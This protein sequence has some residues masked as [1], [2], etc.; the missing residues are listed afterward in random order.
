MKKSFLLIGIIVISVFV[1]L[2]TACPPGGDEMLNYT[3]LDTTISAATTAMVGVSRSEHSGSDV[4]PSSKWV[5][6]EVWDSFYEAITH[7]QTVRHSAVTQAQLDNAVVALNNAISE[8]NHAKQDGT[9]STDTTDL[10]ALITQADII[11]DTAIV[12]TDGSEISPSDYWVTQEEMDALIDKITEAENAIDSEQNIDTAYTELNY[13][14]GIFTTA[15]KPGTQDGSD[16]DGAIELNENTW[17]NNTITATDDEQWYKFTATAEEQFIHFSSTSSWLYL[18]MYDSTGNTVGISVNCHDDKVISRTV[19]NGEIYYIKVWKT[20]N[21][22][23]ET[24]RIAFNRSFIEPETIVTALTEDIWTNGILTETNNEQWFKF[25]ATTN[26]QYIHFEPGSLNVVYVQVYDLNGNT[27]ENTEELHSSNPRIPILVTIGQH[28]VVKVWSYTSY[29]GTFKMAFNSLSIPPATVLAENTWMDS[30]I[31]TTNLEQWFK[32][33]A[34]SNTQ[35]IHFSPGTL[36]DIYVEIFNSSGISIR[37][38]YLNS[39]TASISQTLT[40]GEE[41]FV[42]ITPSISG[43]TGTYRIAFN[44]S[45]TVTPVAS[46]TELVEK[47]WTDGN[48]IV[49]SAGQMFKFIATASEQFIHFSPGTLA[50]V[51]VQLYDSNGSGVGYQT[52]LYGSGSNLRTSRDL[53]IGQEYYVRILPYTSNSTGTYQIA[54]GSII[55]ISDFIVTSG[56]SWADGNI[57][58]NSREQWFM[59]TATADTHFIHFSDGTLNNIYV[60]VY[61]SN[62]NTEGHWTHFNHENMVSQTVTSGQEYYVWVQPYYSNG[63]GTYRIAFNTSIV[64]P[65]SICTQLTENTWTLGTIAKAGGVQLHRFIATSDTQF[66]HYSP[67]TLSTTQMHVQVFDSNGITHGESITLVNNLGVSLAVTNGQEYYFRV[68]PSSTSSTG[69]Y[70]IMFS[71]SIVA[72]GNSVIELTANTWSSNSITTANREHWYKFTAIADTQYI[73]FNALNWETSTSVYIQVYNSSGSAVEDQTNLYLYYS[74]NSIDLNLSTSRT[75]NS[76]EEYYVRVL[77][78]DTNNIGK[79][80]H[81]GFGSIVPPSGFTI[82]TADTWANGIVSVSTYFEQWYKFTATADMQYIHYSPGT[83]YTETLYVQLYN[84][85]GNTVGSQISFNSSSQTSSLMV[86]GGEEYYIKVKINLYGGTYRIGF[87]TSTISPPI[88]LPAADVTEL[89]ENIWAFYE[90]EVEEQWF[91]FIATSNMHYLHYYSSL[92]IDI[93]MQ[94][95]DSNGNRVGSQIDLLTSY[96]RGPFSSPITSIELTSDEE[97]YVRVWPGGSSFGIVGIGG[98]RIA[99]NSDGTVPPSP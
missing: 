93:F 54:F 75:V 11:K 41:Y 89:N 84:L 18:Q 83:L 62:G 67:G 14:I 59:F 81:I 30:N 17:A 76:G 78:Y 3:A 66:I 27:V 39:S 88:P 2:F 53:T 99:F 28:Y 79:T 90:A 85:A 15:K 19:V 86:T 40:I 51:N 16:F 50:S 43:Y 69:T 63:T 56:N 82:L 7:A 55:P 71:N 77:P 26:T 5:T 73:H 74:Q 46:V 20:Y 61:N 72:P 95:Y 96:N 12:S 48:I 24:Y 1:L 65:D 60:Q 57:D 8:F 68:L 49:A 64:A 10:Q 31:I 9:K 33:T 92:L 29:T 38:A 22:Y 32:F 70:L 44:N 91:K 80:Y 94:L 52:R 35:Y 36:N 13:A 58:S 98:L 4:S 25:T 42:R 45:N 87:N 23:M 97:Y 47:T 21:E 6:H 37:I 34:I